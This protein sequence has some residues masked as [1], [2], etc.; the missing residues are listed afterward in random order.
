MCSALC[1]VHGF[2]LTQL[3]YTFAHPDPAMTKLARVAAVILLIATASVIAKG[4]N[5]EHHQDMAA[6]TCGNDHIARVDSTGF[7]CQPPSE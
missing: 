6:Q 3:I 2:E 5:E 7:A 1:G 4:F